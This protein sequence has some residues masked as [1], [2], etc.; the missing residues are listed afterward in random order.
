M[1][2]ICSVKKITGKNEWARW[3]G[4]GPYT[5]KGVKYQ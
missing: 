2:Q 4:V 5:K 1:S 3:E